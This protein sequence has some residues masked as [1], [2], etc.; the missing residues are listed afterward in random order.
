MTIQVF[1]TVSEVREWRES[2]EGTVGLVPTMGALHSG[3]IALVE[4]SFKK[5]DFTII[6]IFVNPSQFAPG[7]DLDSYP[8][9][10]DDDYAK[11]NEFLIIN[12]INSSR[13][14]IFN[15][16]VSEIYPS[17]FNLDINLQKGTFIQVLGPTSTLE[18]KSRPLFFRGVCTV[19]LK[20]FNCTSPN[21]AFFGQKDVQQCI[22]VQRMVKDLLLNLEIVILPIVREVN[23][24]AKS[25]RNKYLTEENLE[26]ASIIYKSLQNGVDLYKKGKSSEDIITFIENEISNELF[27]IDYVSINEPVDLQERKGPIE[28][29]DV[30]S[31][32]VFVNQPDQ[33][34]RLI[35][36]IIF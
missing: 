24:L 3:H 21:Y 27:T 16:T 33:K 4:E 5:S 19:V 31:L 11:L 7:E 29:G 34:V 6:S 17:G 22:V 23:G 20:L 12:K 8:R 9:T 30:L 25:S 2:V 1:R 13:L 15:P 14:I 35:D 18:G 36:N 28:K 32:A 10:F 26:K